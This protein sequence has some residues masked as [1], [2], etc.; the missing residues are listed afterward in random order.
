MNE[1]VVL[2][3]GKGALLTCLLLAAPVLVVSLVLG[4]AIGVFQSVTQINEMTLAFVPKVLGLFATLAI[5]GP[6]MMAKIIDFTMQ[7]I[8]FMPNMV[9]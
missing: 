7:L 1:Q 2:E 8:A 4:L 5:F 6:W 9:H 3:L